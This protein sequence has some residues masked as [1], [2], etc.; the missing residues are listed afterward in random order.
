[1]VWQFLDYVAPV[2]EFRDK[3]FHVHFKDIKLYPRKLA[4]VG[5]MAYPETYMS[6]K[7][8]GL[9]DVKWDEFVSAL[10]DIGYTGYACIEVE[11]RAFEATDQDVQK[12]LFLSKKYMEQFVA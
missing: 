5:I 4:N 7:I 1:M 10:T 6:P 11:D 8:P 9:G 2:Y 12:S 3:I